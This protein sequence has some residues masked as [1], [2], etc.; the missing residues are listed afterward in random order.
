M[1]KNLINLEKFVDLQP[2]FSEKA[3]IL[4]YIVDMQE[5]LKKLMFSTDKLPDTRWFIRTE[6]LGI[7]ETK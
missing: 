5:E 6:L 2:E 3:T 4:K 1:K 7:K